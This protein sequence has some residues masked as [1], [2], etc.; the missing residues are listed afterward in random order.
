[1]WKVVTRNI[2][3]NSF[4]CREEM[5]ARDGQ[6]KGLT[7]YQSSS[8]KDIHTK[9]K[10]LFAIKITSLSQVLYSRCLSVLKVLTECGVFTCGSRMK[11]EDSHVKIV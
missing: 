1:M 8:L 10:T 5:S 2:P 4:S 6:L 11:C 3:E 7:S 9:C